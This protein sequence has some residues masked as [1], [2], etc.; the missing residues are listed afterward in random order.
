MV[1]I[2]V[3]TFNVLRKLRGC[4][5]VTILHWKSHMIRQMVHFYQKTSQVTQF[6]ISYP[7]R[8]IIVTPKF[9]KVF[10]MKNAFVKIPRL[11]IEVRYSGC[12][13][14]YGKCRLHGSGNSKGNLLIGGIC[15]GKD[16]LR[17]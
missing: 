11:Y 16:F 12:P 10:D 6:Q 8:Y 17:Y 4:S 9:R 3:I 15:E 14:M 5:H 13:L 7:Q 2:K 1:T